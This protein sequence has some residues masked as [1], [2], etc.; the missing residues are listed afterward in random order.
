M[1]FLITFALNIA[2]QRI[3]RRFREV[4]E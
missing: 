2:S 4:Y 1:L 3:V